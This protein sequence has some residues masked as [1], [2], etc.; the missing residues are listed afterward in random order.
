MAESTTF[1]TIASAGSLDM[2][3]L[4]LKALSQFNADGASCVDASKR[5]C[6]LQQLPNSASGTA[7]M[8]ADQAARQ[9]HDKATRGELLSSE[10][11]ASLNEWYARQDE[12]ETA[13]LSQA[14]VPERLEGL[15]RD[16]D[17]A[18]TDLRSVAGRIQTLSREN[19]ALRREIAV[20]QRQLVD[21]I[22]AQSA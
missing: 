20:L 1:A 19:E 21:K 14:A 9:L 15:R 2:Q 3:V 10:E 18:M 13:E 6:P 17:A 11:Q 16:V 5:A 4:D 8:I 12:A 22:A 7:T